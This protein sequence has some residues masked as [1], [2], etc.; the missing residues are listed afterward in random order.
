ML[1][2]SPLNHSK[3][4]EVYIR[5]LDKRLIKLHREL[6]LP[7]TF[8]RFE[9]LFSNFLQGNDMPTVQTSDGGVKLLRFVAKSLDMILPSKC[10]KFRISNLAPRLKHADYFVQL[11]NE[12]NL[13]KVVIFIDFDPVNFNILGDGIETEYEV[14]TLIKQS[15]EDVYSI[16][17]YPLASSLTCVKI[18]SAFENKLSVF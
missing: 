17:R 4:L 13:N 1:F 6:R 8:K 3:H 16:S 15:D 2:D 5:L 18:T 12:S 9:Q 7:R 14:K 10:L 11:L